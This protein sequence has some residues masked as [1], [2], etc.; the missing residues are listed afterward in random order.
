M[1]IQE[2]EKNYELECEELKI[3]HNKMC[4]KTINFW[5]IFAGIFIAIGL[6]LIIYANSMPFEK[7]Y[8]G[9]MQKSFKADLMQTYAIICFI[10]GI[11][12]P[13]CVLLSSLKSQEKGP[14]NYLSA[15]KNLYLNYLKCTDMNKEDKLFYTQK[16]EEIRN[17]ELVSAINKAGSAVALSSFSAIMFTSLNK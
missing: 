5:L 6:F 2:A 4:K 10:L 3:A 16:L 17:L 14:T 15:I 7:R 8:D 13:F 11:P 1:T 12:V 9:T